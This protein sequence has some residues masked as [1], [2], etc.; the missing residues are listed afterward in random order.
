MTETAVQRAAS[1]HRERNQELRARFEGRN[2][3][4]SE[5]RPV[6]FHFWAWSQRDAAVLARGLYEMGFLIRLLAP[7]STE[8]D[9]DR[10]TVEA[11]ARIPLEQAL[12]EELTE[13]LIKLAGKENAAFDGW[14]AS[15]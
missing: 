13:K 10:W 1:E 3:D 5:P 15:V 12:G 4:L 9:A 2:L 11:G 8:E 14:G 7:A 6:D